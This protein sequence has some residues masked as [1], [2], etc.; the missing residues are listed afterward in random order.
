MFHRPSQKQ[1]RLLHEYVASTSFH[2]R[3]H[4]VTVSPLFYPSLFLIVSFRLGF[5]WSSSTRLDQPL[6]I[7]Q[8]NILG[9]MAPISKATLWTTI[10]TAM[11]FMCLHRFALVGF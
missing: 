1:Q 7:C 3:S 11:A 8:A 6:V 2:A 9:P 5:M 10:S 4:R